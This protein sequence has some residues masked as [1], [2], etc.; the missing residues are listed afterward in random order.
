MHE[1]LRGHASRRWKSESERGDDNS[2]LSGYPEVMLA[3]EVAKLLRLS[4]ASVYRAVREGSIAA[5]RI[6][7][8]VL[9]PKRA[10][11]KLIRRS[12]QE[13]KGTGT[14]RASSRADAKAKIIG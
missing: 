1:Q 3:G 5:V 4:T 6:N 11:I 8:R 2:D 10:V 12:Q 9:I 13:K 7:R 14:W